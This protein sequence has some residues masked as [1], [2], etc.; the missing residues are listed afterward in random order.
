MSV[1]DSLPVVHWKKTSADF[2]CEVDLESSDEDDIKNI[3]IS[4]NNENIGGY[5]ELTLEELSLYLTDEDIEEKSKNT[6][7]FSIQFLFR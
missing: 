4:I 7:K 1:V 5:D 3:S 6:I 2:T